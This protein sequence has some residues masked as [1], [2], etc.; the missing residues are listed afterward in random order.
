YPQEESRREPRRTHYEKAFKLPYLD[1]IFENY[2]SSAWPTYLDGKPTVVHV[3]I[4]IITLGPFDTAEMDY[5]VEIYLQQSWYDPR[6]NLYRFG[7]NTTLSLNGAEIAPMMW[8]PDLYF[9][10]AKHSAKHDVTMPNELVDISPKGE[11]HYSMRQVL[12]T[13]ELACLMTFRRYPLDI[14]RCPL[15]LG[16]FA[17]TTEQTILKWEETN[18]I[19]YENDVEIPQFLLTE[20]TYDS[21][22]R[23]FD[24][25]LF[26]LLRVEFTVSRDRG[27]Y[28]INMYFPTMLCVVISWFAFYIRLGNAP[29]RVILDLG[30]LLNLLSV[31]TGVR[32]ELPPVSYIKALD[33]WMGACI[34][35]VFGSLLI[36]IMVNY[37]GRI[38]QRPKFYR[39]VDD[40]AF[41]VSITIFQSLVE[42]SGVC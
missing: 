6:L 40:T 15:T 12:L 27:F 20:T 39:L 18:P 4:Y 26:S 9:A 7:V 37:M 24:T 8:K 23:S 10:N 19:V 3:S 33:V 21:Y 29:A 13:L 5:N 42:V 2:D 34:C 30:M 32:S 22:N 38:K 31:N 41:V 17:Q 14:Q 36:F 1:T 25:G 28:L 35:A 11:V 16:T